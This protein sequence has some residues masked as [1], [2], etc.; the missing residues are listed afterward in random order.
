MGAIGKSMIM[1]V[2]WEYR[3][4][5]SY[6]SKVGKM[7]GSGENNQ[8]QEDNDEG[9]GVILTYHTTGNLSGEPR[10]QEFPF[11][12]MTTATRWLH[13]VLKLRNESRAMVGVRTSEE[14]VLDWLERFRTF[15]LEWGSDFIPLDVRRAVHLSQEDLGLECAQW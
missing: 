4:L 8:G 13:T 5:C 11:E 3:T 15:H 14:E 10:T 6:S 1:L 2:T 12:D 7:E 9:G